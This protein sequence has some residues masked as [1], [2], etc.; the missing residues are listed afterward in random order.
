MAWLYLHPTAVE[1]ANAWQSQHGADMVVESASTLIAIK[2]LN[3]IHLIV[4]LFKPI[5]TK[6]TS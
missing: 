2:P 6:A 4:P 5:S 3:S 1:V